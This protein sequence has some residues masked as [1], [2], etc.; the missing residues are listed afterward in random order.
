MWQSRLWC[1]SLSHFGMPMQVTTNVRMACLAAHVDGRK[2]W[3]QN[4]VIARNAV[5]RRRWCRREPKPEGLL[6][7][8]TGK[9]GKSGEAEVDP[10]AQSLVEA[11]GGRSVTCSRTLALLKDNK[12]RRAQCLDVLTHPPSYRTPAP[13][14]FKSHDSY[15]S[16]HFLGFPMRLPRF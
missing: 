3:T 10:P 16:M 2:D 7:R 1:G 5:A 13:T 12:T 4:V 6:R 11:R 9:D 8:E 15:I 14:H